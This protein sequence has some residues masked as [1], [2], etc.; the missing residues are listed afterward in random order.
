MIRFL[1]WLTGVVALAWGIAWIADRPGALTVDWLGYRVQTPLAVA[2]AALVAAIVLVHVAYR[3]VH[4]TWHA[5]NAVSNFFRSRR[6]RRGY[7]ALSRG[8]V[9][10]GAGDLVTARRQTMIASRMLD[11]EPLTKVLEAQ[12]AQLAGD[13]AKVQSIFAAMAKAPET[14]LLGLRGVFRQARAEGNRALARTIAEEALK[15]NAGLPWASSAM[16]AIQSSAGDW[17][18]V[19]RTLESQR[20]FHLIDE[21]TAQRKRAVALTAQAMEVEKTD[22]SEALALALRAHRLDVSFVPAAMVAARCHAHKGQARKAARLIEQ[23]WRRHPHAGLA[24]L[25]AFQ[26]PSAAAPER[27][28][29][30]REL[31]TTAAGGEEGAVALA[32]AALEA[33]EWPAAREALAPYVSASPNSRV[34]ALMAEIAEGEGDKGLAREWLSRAVRAPRGPQWTADGFVSDEWLPASPVTGE[35][36]AFQWRVPVEG[37]AIEARPEFPTSE[38]MALPEK[39]ET[40]TEVENPIGTATALPLQA[41]TPPAPDAAS[42]G[43]L[44]RPPDDPGPPREEVATGIPRPWPGRFSG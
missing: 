39:A 38:A 17:A 26:K 23:T 9:A 41:P 37:L 40:P 2:G 34:C 24:R 20:R 32:Q 1:L 33:R 30:V 42:R 31:L 10:V 19:L 29:R 8:I 13:T 27:L 4:R 15:D 5:P 35:L 12:T 7:E 43:S 28:K 16:L 25:Y 22:P 11:F 36:G 14:K 18:G 6:H 21:T 44:P 3:L